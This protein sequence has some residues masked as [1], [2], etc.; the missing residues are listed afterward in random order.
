MTDRLVML[1]VDDDE[2]FRTLAEAHFKLAGF[3]VVSAGDA[4]EALD[5]LDKMS[6]LDCVVSDIWLPKGTPHGVSLASMVGARF[7]SAVRILISGDPEARTY[8]NK[9]EGT[10]F[11]KPADFSAII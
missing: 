5:R 1:L 10:L 7:P 9:G 4:M 2:V 8:V 11:S 3:D 6:A